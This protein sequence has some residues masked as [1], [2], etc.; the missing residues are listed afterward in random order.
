MQL[1]IRTSGA[2]IIID[3]I[4][5][6]AY[7]ACTNPVITTQPSSSSVTA[8]ATASFTV[9]ATGSSLTY[10]WQVSTNGGTSWANVASGTGGT[11]NTYT[12][13]STT[14]VMNGYLYRVLVSSGSCTTTSSTSTLTVTG[15]SCTNPVI[16]SHPSPQTVS[17]G[18][19]ASFSATATGANL[20]Y[21]WQVST[22]GGSSFSNIP[23][24]FSATYNTGATTIAMN[25]Y[26]YR[27]IVLSD[28]GCP[29]TSNSAT[30]T[31]N[32]PALSTCINEGFENA[33]F[34]PAGWTQANITRSNATADVAVGTW[35]AVFQATTGTLVTSSVA[36]PNTLSF[37]LGRT[38]NTTAKTLTVSVSTTSATAGFTV[39]NTYTHSNI[40]A[41]SY[42]QY[43]IDLTA[44]NSYSNV[45]IKFEKNY[46]TTTSPWRLDQ[47]VLTCGLASPCT[48][49]T[50]QPTSLTFGPLTG[51]TQTSI[52]GVFTAASPAAHRYLVIRSIGAFT[53]T[54]VNGVIYNAGDVIGN[55]IVVDNDNNTSFSATGLA[56]ATVYTFT[57]FSYNA[58]NCSVPKYNTVSPLTGTQTTRPNLVTNFKVSCQNTTSAT[59]TWTNPTGMDGVIILARNSTANPNLPEATALPSTITANSVFSSGSVVGTGTPSTYAVYKGT[60]NSVTVTGLTAGQPYRF[61]AVAYKVENY[62]SNTIPTT[63]IV[64]LGTAEINSL[65]GI[66]SSGQLALSWS[67]P[68]AGCFDQVM[69]VVNEGAVTLAPSGDGSAYTANSVYNGAAATD[70]V[71]YK[72]TGNAVNVTGLINGRTYCVKVFVR[73]GTNWSNGISSCFEIVTTTNFNTGELFFTAFDPTIGGSGDE[74]LV[75]TLVDIV[76]GTKFSIVN[77]RYEAGAAASVRTNKWGGPG[78]D[79]SLMPGIMEVTWLGPGNIAAGTVIDIQ[80]YLSPTAVGPY[81]ATAGTQYDVYLITPGGINLSS[82]FQ[83]S[84]P[85]GSVA[86]NISSSAP[87]QIYLIQGTFYHDGTP[88]TANEANWYLNGRALFAI[89]N[90]AG[91]VPFNTVNPGGNASSNPTLRTSR[92]PN[93]VACFNMVNASTTYDKYAYYRNSAI[94]AG[95]KREIIAELSKTSTASIWFIGNST[96]GYDLN[97]AVSTTYTE[98]GAP[99]T[100]LGD[101]EPGAWVGDK[102]NNWFD[103]AN[104]GGLAV[105]NE[106]TNVFLDNSIIAVGS[107]ARVISSDPLALQ[108]GSVAKASNLTINASGKAVE[109]FTGTSDKLQVYRNI[110]LE[111]GIL[112]GGSGIIGLQGEM[113]LNGGSF[114]SETGTFIYNSNAGDQNIAEVTYNHLVFDSSG[115]R[116]APA[117]TIQVKGNL[118]G[119]QSTSFVHNNGT[120][121]LI[122]S[123]ASTYTATNPFTFYNLTSGNTAML[124]IGSAATV[125]NEYK[126][127]NSGK[128]TLNQDITLRSTAAN[129]AFVSAIPTSAQF[130]YAA[131][132]G[133]VV[134]RYM[135][136]YR[137]WELVSPNTYD[138]TFR[139]SWQ[140]G[141]GASAG[142]GTKITHPGGGT[143][144]DG[145]SVTPS[146]KYYNPATD[147]YTGINNTLT[148]FNTQP[149]YFLFHYGDRAGGSTTTLR[150]KGKLFSNNGTGNQAVATQTVSPGLFHLTG[151]PYVSRLSI[152]SFLASNPALV[153]S[154]YV[155]DPALAGVWGA[156]AYQTIS[157]SGVVTP[158]GGGYY[159]GTE[160]NIESGQAFF[161][162]SGG[163]SVLLNFSENH[164]AA[165][166][167]LVMRQAHEESMFSVMLYKSN[168]L[169]DGVRLMFDNNYSNGIDVYDADKR[170]NSQENLGIVINNKQY[171]VE[172]R[173][174]FAVTDTVHLN[175]VLYGNYPFMFG[176][177][178]QN[179][180]G[181]PLLSAYLVDRFKNEYHPVSLT[182]S[183]YY[184]FEVNTD[185]ASK[186]ADR[187]YIVFEKA[188]TGKL[189]AINA[190][191]NGNKDI[192]HFSLDNEAGITGYEV[193]GSRNG[194]AFDLVQGIDAVGNLQYSATET[195][196][197]VYAKWYRVKVYYADGSFTYSQ[198]VKIEPITKEQI[199]IAGP[200]KDGNIDLVVQNTGKG[201]YPLQI[202]NAA[203]QIVYNSSINVANL[204]E[205]ITLKTGITAKGSYVLRVNYKPV[206]FI[207]K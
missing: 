150:S 166:S 103:C 108:Y 178:V 100:M 120:V 172:S 116:I 124:N 77:S 16:T 133:F 54:P 46:S 183:S 56:A 34:P 165:G 205:R 48:A 69:V 98:A 174:P 154:V 145:N 14:V 99:F 37:Y 81:T 185:P 97:I 105:P 85:A 181:H 128:I 155:W 136:K 36:Y 21:Q 119:M 75:A 170:I 8:P 132:K 164:K 198:T 204:Y 148:S 84:V 50:A 4:I 87:D 82:G 88:G 43:S 144:I 104:W 27:V 26:Q 149:G 3:D 58:N 126:T 113:I 71:V 11:T 12:T 52:A 153:Q 159:N 168:E 203:G 66:V 49:P 23:G 109:V 137:K 25:G 190:E 45:W 63:G 158:G 95:S 151:N 57:I 44:Y 191:R 156:G 134:E 89:T 140:E 78:D 107:N 41:G 189:I 10:Q 122:G 125:L 187:F 24:A 96:S 18:S 9:A 141:G 195:I 194:Q 1:Q 2:Q 40:P 118:T 111:S 70:Q 13:P 162:K 169:M 29:V 102:N 94:H 55:G 123:V 62:S 20:S 101:I 72:G 173:K 73:Q 163:A 19:A 53:G 91:W 130:N 197:P 147:D 146:L 15:V 167:R 6:T 28:G 112:K 196:L 68:A 60:G 38:S 64:S 139:N 35:A 131:G 83:I 90:G 179:F 47:V 143:G 51:I 207:I 86:P 22:N 175:T 192:I 76:P 115:Q 135:S 30:L 142:Y 157:A 177:S 31:V 61:L 7:S 32:P 193:E 176:F 161:V 74:Y 129:S 199:Y 180:T 59:L 127:L 106:N 186:A 184:N 80:N 200:V 17:V 114:N 138:V 93:D 121:E 5:W 152:P 42:N 117:T 92:L 188:P 201:T 171:A 160:S 65:N 67:N 206:K 39:V 79:A 33:T 202:I 110:I 182:D